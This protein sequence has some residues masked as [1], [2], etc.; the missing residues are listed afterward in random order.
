MLC[1]NEGRYSHAIGTKHCFYSSKVLATPESLDAPPLEFPPGYQGNNPYRFKLTTANSLVIETL[2]Q[3]TFPNGA[4]SKLW[5]DPDLAS[6]SKNM[7]VLHNNWIVSQDAKIQRQVK[8]GLWYFIED[9]LVCSYKR[10]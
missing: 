4:V 6:K 9:S 8:Q 7:Y 2:N 1:G 5:D 10:T 3:Y